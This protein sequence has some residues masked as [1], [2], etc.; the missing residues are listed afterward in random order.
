MTGLAR[1][2][3]SVVGSVPTAAGFEIA[4]MVGGPEDEQPASTGVRAAMTLATRFRVMVRSVI[5]GNQE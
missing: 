1:V 5:E 3:V 2:A 4:A